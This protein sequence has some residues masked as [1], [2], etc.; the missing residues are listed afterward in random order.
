MTVTYD[1]VV[2]V[3]W[4]GLCTIANSVSF[5]SGR[6]YRNVWRTVDSYPEVVVDLV[7]DRPLLVLTNQGKYFIQPE[8]DIIYR[9]E[10]IPDDRLLEKAVLVSGVGAIIDGIRSSTT[11]CPTWERIEVL[12]VNYKYATPGMPVAQINEAKISV[13]LKKEWVG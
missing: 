7:R 8:F 13:R 9:Q 11:N 2:N 5:L 12:D 1:S 10:S 4:S 3:M 6:V